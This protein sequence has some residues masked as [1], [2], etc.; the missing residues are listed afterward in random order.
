MHLPLFH[1]WPWHAKVADSEPW[2]I[3]S[4]VPKEH[5]SDWELTPAYISLL[6]VIHWH[7]K[8][9]SPHSKGIMLVLSPGF[10][11]D[12]ANKVGELSVPLCL[13]WNW[14][15]KLPCGNSDSQVGETW[16]LATSTLSLYIPWISKCLSYFLLIFLFKRGV[17]TGIWNLLTLWG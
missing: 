3:F 7:G 11:P 1:R 2:S 10:F 4:T 5:F 12:F 14:L 15:N 16:M 8:D 13:Y 6:C 9:I 17:K